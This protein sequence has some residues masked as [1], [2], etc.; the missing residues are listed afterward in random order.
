ML[1]PHL[2]GKTHG[3]ENMWVWLPQQ[4]QN[5]PSWLNHKTRYVVNLQQR[6]KTTQNWEA[7]SMLNCAWTK[8]C[9]PKSKSIN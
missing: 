2:P 8:T 1:V 7:G 4:Q 5:N 3:I 9:T 6:Y